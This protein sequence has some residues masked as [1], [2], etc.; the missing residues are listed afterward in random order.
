MNLKD[1]SA[2]DAALQDVQCLQSS[3]GAFAALCRAG[4]V[5]AWGSADYGG[6]GPAAELNT[7]ESGN[8][9]LEDHVC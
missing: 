5:V 7:A 8:S 9:D 3:A 6:L 1:C 2:A 4:R